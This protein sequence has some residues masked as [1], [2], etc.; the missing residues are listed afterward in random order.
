MFTPIEKWIRQVIDQLVVGQNVYLAPDSAPLLP[1][2][3]IHLETAVISEIPAAGNTIHIKKADGKVQI[4]DVD[5][6]S[7]AYLH[8]GTV[9]IEGKIRT[10]VFLSEENFWAWWEWFILTDKLNPYVSFY[11]CSV[12]EIPTLKNLQICRIIADVLVNSNLRYQNMDCAD[13]DH[14]DSEDKSRCST[15]IRSGT[16]KDYWQGEKRWYEP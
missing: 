10:W 2:K 16:L 1:A 9:D 3:E 6:R 15:C 4:V 11:Q 14:R 5:A 7:T 8:L 12:D 13:C